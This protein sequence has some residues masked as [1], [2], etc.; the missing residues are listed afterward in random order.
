MSPNQRLCSTPSARVALTALQALA[1][2]QQQLSADSALLEQQ[3]TA[4]AARRLELVRLKADL[5]ECMGLFFGALQQR[6]QT[7]VEVMNRTAAEVSFS[8]L[9]QGVKAV[10]V[11]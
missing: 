11:G 7:E 6:W 8:E 5:L 4:A 10:V 1:S 2:R 3:L 9:Y